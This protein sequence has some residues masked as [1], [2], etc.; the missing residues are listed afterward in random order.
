M[1]RRLSPASL[2]ATL[3]PESTTEVANGKTEAPHVQVR[4]LWAHPTRRQVD[5]QQAHGTALL[6]ARQGVREVSTLNVKNPDQ[7]DY[8]TR[9]GGDLVSPIEE[10]DEAITDLARVVWHTA[11][12][13]EMAIEFMPV[14]G[15]LIKARR[16]LREVYG[17]A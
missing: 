11:R 15:H 3:W 14:I 9:Q 5:L 4:P 7:R 17:K 16:S 1:G 6:L 12:D 10:L 2:H 13:S 8:E